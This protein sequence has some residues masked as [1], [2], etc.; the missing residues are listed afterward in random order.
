MRNRQTLLVAPYKQKSWVSSPEVAPAP[1]FTGPPL[2]YDL[3]TDEMENFKHVSPS[4]SK[5]LRRSQLGDLEWNEDDYISD[6]EKFT[7]NKLYSRKL[8]LTLSEESECLVNSRNEES[9]EKFDDELQ[10]NWENTLIESIKG[11]DKT[12]SLEKLF[13]KSKLSDLSG[14]IMKIA[15]FVKAIP[16]L[17][18]ESR[19]SALTFLI[20]LDYL[21]KG[22][23]THWQITLMDESKKSKH[24]KIRKKMQNE[25]F[26]MKDDIKYNI[27]I[28]DQFHA[29]AY[30]MTSRLGSNELANILTKIE[31][32]F[33]K[34]IFRDGYNGCKIHNLKKLYKHFYNYLPTFFGQGFKGIAIISKMKGSSI[35]QSFRLGI[36]YGFW[37][38]FAIFSY[39][40]SAI[41]NRSGKEVIKDKLKKISSLVQLLSIETLQEILK[42]VSILKYKD[43][44]KEF[45]QLS[46][47]HSHKWYEIL[48]EMDIEPEMKVNMMNHINEFTDELLTTTGVNIHN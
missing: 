40:M 31:E 28:G 3:N 29:I 38:Q 41:E 5:S 10:R 34:I 25:A 21:V 35:D 33:A 7:Q 23:F 43:F 24:S 4:N 26:I 32:N 37:M 45:A 8:G 17:T 22:L 16:I 27:L 18:P 44:K 47:M 11:I 1:E 14:E 12:N 36:E 46:I 6:F 20:S 39:I 30:H 42:S 9:N 48:E 15:G 19:T 13:R 2:S